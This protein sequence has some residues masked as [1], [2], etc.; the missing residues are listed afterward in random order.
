[1]TESDLTGSLRIA[2]KQNPYASIDV[3]DLTLMVEFPHIFTSVFMSFSRPPRNRDGANGGLVFSEKRFHADET[4]KKSIS[5]FPS[6]C[7]SN[8]APTAGS[9]LIQSASIVASYTWTP[10]QPL[11][12]LS[13]SV[14]DS[15][16]AQIR[17]TTK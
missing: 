5:C 16:A 4:V 12:F 1:M 8:H 2:A 9:E 6:V 10:F 7:S 14:I 13:H 11:W 3:L 15:C 17:G